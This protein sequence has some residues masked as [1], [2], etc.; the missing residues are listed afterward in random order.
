MIWTFCARGNFVLNLRLL[1]SRL[2]RCGL[3]F[4]G[5]SCALLAL[6]LHRLV[7][8]NQVR[9]YLPHHFHQLFFESFVKSRNFLFRLLICSWSFSVGNLSFWLRFLITLFR[10]RNSFLAVIIGRIGIVLDGC[11]LLFGGCRLI[12]LALLRLSPRFRCL[13]N[14][15]L[16]FLFWLFLNGRSLSFTKGGRESSL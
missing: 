15:F 1:A 8:L 14:F 16:R 3:S 9:V 5:C 4:R 11:W 10:H 2:P 13:S 7:E 12:V 6:L